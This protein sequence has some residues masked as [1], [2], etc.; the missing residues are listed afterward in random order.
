[1]L[2]NFSSGTSPSYAAA[3]AA[4]AVREMR[5]RLQLYNTMARSKETFKARPE[6]PERVQMHVCG[7]TVYDYSHIG[8]L[9]PSLP[10][11]A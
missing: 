5:E 10:G 11:V 9:R 6:H 4:M 7:V 1:M 2:C 3:N 8:G